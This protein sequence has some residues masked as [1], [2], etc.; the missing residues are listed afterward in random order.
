MSEI[1]IP[2]W[3]WAIFGAVALIALGLFVAFFTWLGRN[4]VDQGKQLA[5]SNTQIL[6]VKSQLRDINDKIDAI[7]YAQIEVHTNEIA[8]IREEMSTMWNRINRN[9]P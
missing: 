1:L 4:I 5:V 6:D 2:G 3:A 7:P 9:S 8:R